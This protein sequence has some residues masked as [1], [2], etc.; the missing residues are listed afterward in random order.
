VGA[1][2]VGIGTVF[3]LK[4][5]SKS[6]DG[7]NLFNSCNHGPG[8]NAE[9][10]AQIGQYDDDA[11]SARTLAIVGYAVGGA[12]VVTGILMLALDKGGS[13]SAK[14]GHEPNVQPW[15]GLGTAGVSGRF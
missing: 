7:D 2:G 5:M 10:K 11:T 15:V 8:C 1:V 6:S 14:N 12:G 4:S 9:Q 13:S 3:L